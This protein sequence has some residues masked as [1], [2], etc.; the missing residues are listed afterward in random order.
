MRKMFNT[1]ESLPIYE[2]CQFAEGLRELK[3]GF[4]TINL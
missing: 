1:V 3:H 4:R 2:P